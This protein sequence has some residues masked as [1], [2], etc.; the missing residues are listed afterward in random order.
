MSRY[1]LRRQLL[2]AIPG[3][4]LREPDAAVERCCA[5]FADRRGPTPAQPRTAAAPRSPGCAN[6][7][8][9]VVRGQLSTSSNKEAPDVSRLFPPGDIPPRAPTLATTTAYPP[10]SLYP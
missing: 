8:A 3:G 4:D 7:N 2:A 9:E 1:N 5:E 6:P 10:L